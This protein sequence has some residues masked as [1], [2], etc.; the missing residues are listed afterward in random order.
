MKR[1][2]HISLLIFIGTFH[3]GCDKSEGWDCFKKAGDTITETR[4]LGGFV[5]VY[6]EGKL[7]IEYHYATVAYVEVTFGENIIADIETNVEGGSLY[8]SNETKCNWTRNM[9]KT[10]LVGIYAPTLNLFENQI[11]GDIQF[12]D[13]L[14]SDVFE[15]DHWNAN[16][17]V[18]ML[19]NAN[20]VKISAHTGYANISVVGDCQNTELYSGAVC[21]FEAQELKASS[22]SVN[23]SSTY[24]ISCY[25]SG[26]LYGNVNLSG[27]IVY[28][29]N[30]DQIDT[31]I[32]GSG[33]VRPN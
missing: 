21:I 12:I 29:G 22:A 1:L 6:A 19:L 13:T 28:S 8:I 2:L 23:N 15:Y 3:L 14:Y 16:G 31:D 30:P 7:N 5:N 24:N 33:T 9:S 11:A 27:D 20:T 32:Q 10:A 26:Y 18:S 17:E 4:Q 25:S